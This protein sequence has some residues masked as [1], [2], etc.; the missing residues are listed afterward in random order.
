MLYWNSDYSIKNAELYDMGA[1]P[2]EE[3]YEITASH[4][5]KAD[6]LKRKLLA[7][8]ALAART[9]SQSR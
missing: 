9:H 5:E 8:Q 4:P 7:N 2:T 6:A 3:G 1:N